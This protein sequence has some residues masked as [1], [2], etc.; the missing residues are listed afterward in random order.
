MKRSVQVLGLAFFLLGQSALAADEQ[1]IPVW[2]G[3]APGSESWSWTEESNTTAPDHSLSFRN[4]VKPTITVFAAAKP[5]GTGML[6]IPG[7]GFRSLAYGKEGETIARWF[8]SIG[9]TAF[10]LKYRLAKTGDEEANDPVKLRARAQ[11]DIPLAIADAGEAIRI[12]R[13][14]SSEWGLKHLGV[15]GFSAGGLLTVTTAMLD[16][17]MRPDFIVP[18]YAAAPHNIPVTADSPPCF[19]VL[20][21]NDRYGTE[22][23]LE[24]YKAWH[25]AK[26]PVEMHIYAQGDHGFALRKNNIPTDRW[27]ERLVDWMMQYGLL[28]KGR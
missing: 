9:V 19:L 3:V 10:V 16:K 21:D 27:N 28:P 26:A 1:V 2:P 11:A 25:A 17:P 8:N 24:I 22:W 15:I 20:A 7:G 6:V 4:I 13:T 14:R 18:V 12:L 23:S 5:N